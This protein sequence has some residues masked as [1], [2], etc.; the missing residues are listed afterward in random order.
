MGAWE[1]EQSV[2][3]QRDGRAK[4][5]G[6]PQSDKTFKTGTFSFH[7]ESQSLDLSLEVTT[8]GTDDFLSFL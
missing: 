7:R 5:V 4:R 3:I 1:L 6:T 8:V 2:E